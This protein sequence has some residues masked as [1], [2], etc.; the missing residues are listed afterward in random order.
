M[1]Y[2]P[3]VLSGFAF[4]ACTSDQAAV[5]PVPSTARTG[6]RASAL[7][8]LPE[9]LLHASEAPDRA[10][11]ALIPEYAGA[12]LDA[13]GDLVIRL[14]KPGREI[15][16]GNLLL[17]ARHG[18]GE[19]GARAAWAGRV[20]GGEVAQFTFAQL[21]AWRRSL[22]PLLANDEDGVFID[23]DENRNRVEVGGRT[24]AFEQRLRVELTNLAI[25]DGAVLFS[26]ATAPT[27]TNCIA[28]FDR[29]RPLAGGT[30]MQAP[31]SPICTIGFPGMRLWPFPPMSL[32]TTA[33]HCAGTGNS[34]DGGSAWQPVYDP[35]DGRDAYEIFDRQGF[36]CRS[37]YPYWCRYAD[38]AAYAIDFASIDTLPGEGYPFVPGRVARTTFP[39][40]I[41]GDTGSKTIDPAMPYFNR[42]GYATP[43]FGM[44]VYKMGRRTG[45]TVGLVNG[46]CIDTANNV[47]IW[48]LCQD[49]ATYQSQGGD[50]GGP[51]MTPSTQVYNDVYFVG[52]HWGTSNGQGWFS[53]M[54]QIQ[55]ETGWIIGF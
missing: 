52:I 7:E 18:K 17:D 40:A 8:T 25:P 23:L 48:L 35:L 14:T 6:L 13:N 2:L 36:I 38:V 11:A 26:N 31:P 30:E 44:Y 54:N 32:V 3:V 15:E 39:S 12:G 34:S 55:S 22:L 5:E 28:L 42:V 37:S 21:S 27:V 24:R 51:V 41:G 53:N 43:F 49:R 50:S 1:R 16:A 47:G 19:V 46:T 20:R 33:G 9:S 29:C 45:W 10:V 4:V